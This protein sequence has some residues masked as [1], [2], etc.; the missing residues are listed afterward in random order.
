MRL[1][2]RREPD[3]RGASPHSVMRAA[4]DPRARRPM[5]LPPLPALRPGPLLWCVPLLVA[6]L[7]W[8]L[9]GSGALDV[10]VGAGPDVMR[11]FYEPEIGPSGAFRWSSRDAALTLPAR[12]RPAV[13]ELRGAVAPDGTRV[14]VGLGDRAAVELPPSPGALSPRRYLLL[15]P[16][17]GDSLG[18][19]RVAL[20][21]TPPEVTVDS[22]PL[23]IALSAVA[24][25][26][27][28][29]GPGLPPPSVLL[30]LVLLPPLLAVCLRATGLGALSSRALAV[31]LVTGAW[32]ASFA[33]PLAVQPLLLDLQVALSA[34]VLR[35][36]GALL[37]LGLAGLPI[38]AFLLRTLPLRGLLFARGAALVLV[39]WACWY[40]SAVLRAPFG[41][42]TVLAVALL[43]VASGAWALR[44]QGLRELG[45]LVRR[46]WRALVAAEVL[47]HAALLAGLWLR[48]NGAVGPALT[49][50][51]KPMDLALLQGVLRDPALPPPD[52]WLAG[53]DVNYYY[54]GYVKV[55]AVAHLAGVTPGEAFNLGV[56]T[57]FA[58]TAAMVAGLVATLVRLELGPEPP[59]AAGRSSDARRSWFAARPRSYVAAA[60]LGAALVLLAGNQMGALQLILGGSQ[61]RVLDGGQLAE[62]LWQRLS[63]APEIR[64]SRPTPPAPDFGVLQ[65]WTPGPTSEF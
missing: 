49:G 14:T 47:F 15:W 37:L 33:Q 45:R 48:W 22:R 19:A 6:C 39:G 35:W 40:A 7:A 57:L 28:R 41:P 20:A 29:A 18:L 51:E 4:Y 10:A 27:L 44:S 32:L 63:G 52:L 34:P 5:K 62:A 38:T 50:T 21:A 13:L 58:L 1:A 53:Y 54:L 3:Q 2:G 42:P 59:A 26:P 36:A 31:A 8:Q 60:L 61:P 23:G 12:P 64:L 46:R 25:R 9:A 16:G 43:L 55:A 11:G 65:G 17:G 24:L 30:A 56:A